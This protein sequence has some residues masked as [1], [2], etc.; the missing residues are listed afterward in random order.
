MDYINQF[1]NSGLGLPTV[2]L[3][4]NSARKLHYMKNRGLN[5]A[6][7]VAAMPNNGMTYQP[8]NDQRAAQ[9]QS[10]NQQAAAQYV[11]SQQMLAQ[12]QPVANLQAQFP[13]GGKL[14]PLAQQEARSM[15]M[16][17]EAYIASQR[18]RGADRIAPDGSSW[19]NPK[20]GKVDPIKLLNH[21]QFSVLSQQDPNKAK[22]LFSNL[23]GTTLEDAQKLFTAQR[24]VENKR[25]TTLRN[26]AFD[27]FNKGM[28][29]RNPDDPTKYQYR[30]MVPDIAT[31]AL[32]PGDWTNVDINTPEIGEIVS[33]MPEIFR[34]SN[35][36]TAPTAPIVPPRYTQNFAPLQDRRQELTQANSWAVT[37]PE[38]NIAFGGGVP[39]Q[40]R[41]TGMN[42]VH[43]RQTL[44]NDPT[45]MKLL[46]T[47]PQRARAI[48]LATQF[49]NQTATAP[50]A[51]VE[52][53]PESFG[54]Y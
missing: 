54:T 16:T 49:K 30:P 42:P 47:D 6:Q 21:P 19:I 23:S 20:M 27:M 31:G 37:G 15:G 14:P 25:Q 32:K 48:I 18:I 43:A 46:Q 8:T 22:Q 36:P 13:I 10:W 28:I 1:D 52:L 53:T 7:Q 5:S 29:Q 44:Q 39:A 2:S 17:P 38:S 3:E 51:P 35:R 11:A 45:F 9:Q 34:M 33:Y 50:S 24:E 12:Q 26:Q 41:Q 4:G 40:L